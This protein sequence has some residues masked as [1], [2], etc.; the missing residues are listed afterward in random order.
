MGAVPNYPTPK[1]ERAMSTSKPSTL[2]YES[3]IRERDG[4]VSTHVIVRAV[5]I[6]NMSA[7]L[8]GAVDNKAGYGTRDAARQQEERFRKALELGHAEHFEP[9][10]HGVH[11]ELRWLHAELTDGR[12]GYCSPFWEEL[13]R[14]YDRIVASTAFVRKVGKAIERQLYKERRQEWSH[15]SLGEVDD[16]TFHD[17]G[18][19]VMALDRIKVIHVRRDRDLDMF[20]RVADSELFK[21]PV[22]SPAPTRSQLVCCV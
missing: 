14:S 4:Y 21:P 9:L 5:R 11:L 10:W 15:A 16:N 17:P 1:K 8:D 7:E 3:F 18:R 19:F 20:V 6:E 22:G 2:T 13:G 12:W